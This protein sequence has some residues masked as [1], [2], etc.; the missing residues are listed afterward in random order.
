M[1]GYWMLDVLDALYWIL[2]A[3]YTFAC[4]ESQVTSNKYPVSNTKAINR[5][6]SWNCNQKKTLIS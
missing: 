5:L 4:G 1:A 3:G 2:D 6:D